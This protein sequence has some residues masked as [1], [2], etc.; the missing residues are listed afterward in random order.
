MDYDDNQLSALGTEHFNAS[1]LKVISSYDHN[2]AIDKLAKHIIKL[3]LVCVSIF[4]A[5]IVNGTES[6]VE[7]YCSDNSGDDLKDEENFYPILNKRMRP[8]LEG[9][10]ICEWVLD[11]KEWVFG[12]MVGVEAKTFEYVSQ[13]DFVGVAASRL[14]ATKR[15]L[16]PSTNKDW[17][18]TSETDS[19]KTAV[20]IPFYVMDDVNNG[21]NAV[22]ALRREQAKIFTLRDIGNVLQYTDAIAACSYH[23]VDVYEK[24]HEHHIHTKFVSE[25]SPS[26]THFWVHDHI[27]SAC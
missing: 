7:L 3:Q 15:I 18:V 6:L 4:L 20:F 23:L 26:S 12:R 16:R 9:T 11:H 25:L 21:P 10:G 1:L 13:S 27:V 2:T 19:E 22:L 5:T 17:L 8:M 14:T 24:K